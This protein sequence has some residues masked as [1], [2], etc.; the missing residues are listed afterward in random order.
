VKNTLDR[1]TGS[2]TMYRLALGCLAAIAVVAL[3]LSALGILAY[4]PVQ[5]LASLA[6]AVGVTPA[7]GLLFALLFRA[8]AH[9]ESSLITGLI[10]FMLFLP[11]FEP[12][13][14]LALAL[15]ATIASASKFLLAVRGRHI[16]NPAAIGAV[17]VA[18][19][20]FGFAGWWIATPPLLPVVALGAFLILYRNRKLSFGLTFVVVAAAIIVVRLSLSVS[21]PLSALT[22][23]FT[24]YP[25][26][27]LVGFMLSEPLTLPPRRWQQLL[28]AIL[29]G[30]LFAV[31]FSIP[32]V[33]SSPELALVLGNLVAFVF[34]QRRGIALTSITKRQLTA[35]TWEF[36]FEASRPVSFSP[37]QYMELG[38]PHGKTDS[39]GNRRYF[40]ISS[41]PTTDGPITFAM[42]IS[43]PS[44]SFK[45]AML[46]LEP[47]DRVRGT[48][49]GGD[50][51]LPK[52]TDTSVLLIAGG[53]GITPFASQLSDAHAHGVNRNTRV[54]YSVRDSSEL[55]YADLLAETAAQVT[56]IAPTSPAQLPANWSYAGSE[57]LTAESLTALVPDIA[58]RR[59]FVSG[60]SALI[61]SVTSVARAAGA[62]RIVTDTF[63]G[64]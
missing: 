28:V 9:V 6:V 33:Y 55:A 29:V 14:L 58:S 53:I 42:T 45:T 47:G 32:P 34:G 46:A 44:S 35:T 38:L 63:S 17:V 27:F 54:I 26:V 56:I 57:R 37:G 19:A 50:F 59:V 52:D 25:I 48:L 36:A 12:T 2:L 13:A 1:L 60:S 64:Y 62:K 15:A 16:F 22:T 23:A 41:P 40:S 10:L 39:R 4:S 11:S 24:S 30:V 21:D 7:T 18:L 5:L 43:N 8:K 61:N 31:P 51:I 20:G 3:V 49:V